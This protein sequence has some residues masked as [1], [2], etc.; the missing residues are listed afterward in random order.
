MTAW[1]KNTL[2]GRLRLL[3]EVRALYAPP[4]PLLLRVETRGQ[5]CPPGHCLE[6]A[7][8]IKT[9]AAFTGKST[10]N[11]HRESSVSPSA[12]GAPKPNPVAQW[13]QAPHTVTP[14]APKRAGITMQALSDHHVLPPGAT[15]SWHGDHQ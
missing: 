8:A 4:P 7:P 13:G 15:W 10:Q 1:S 5:M 14:T 11:N 3:E 2:K 12:K 6:Q 9:T